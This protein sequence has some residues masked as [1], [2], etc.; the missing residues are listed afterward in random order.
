MSLPY[1]KPP[2]PTLPLGAQ[3]V[4]PNTPAPT[5]ST[6]Q[7]GQIVFDP[8]TG[9]PSIVA[10]SSNGNVLTSLRGPMGLTGAVGMQGPMGPPGLKGQ[11]VF[12]GTNK[13][14]SVDEIIE[15]MDVMKKRMLVLTPMFELHEKYPALKQAYDDYLLIEKLVSG[16]QPDEQ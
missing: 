3:V 13:S 8:N 4:N 9:T 5:P 15:F 10:P 6:M 16:D 1:P 7:V 12:Q 11:T 14:I 2:T